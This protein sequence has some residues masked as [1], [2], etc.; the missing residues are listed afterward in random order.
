[1][2]GFVMTSRQPLDA[3]APVSWSE[4]PAKDRPFMSECDAAYKAL[5]RMRQAVLL[6]QVEEA[7]TSYADFQDAYVALSCLLT[8]RFPMPEDR[9]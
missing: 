5:M 2:F 6:E 4:V 9:R 3:Q 7:R 8:E 1:M